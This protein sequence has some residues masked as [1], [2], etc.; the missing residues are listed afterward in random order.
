MLDRTKFLT[1][2]VDL[3]KI[4]EQTRLFILNNQKRRVLQGDHHARAG[5]ILI[6][7][8]MMSETGREEVLKRQKELRERKLSRIRAFVPKTRSTRGLR[9]LIAIAGLL[10]VAIANREFG[11]S[12]E[13]AVAT[14]GFLTYVIEALVEYRAGRPLILSLLRAAFPVMTLVV[15][16]LVLFAGVSIFK[17]NS[18]V[19]VHSAGQVQAQV[20]SRLNGIRI[21]FVAM[22]GALAILL[23][24][25][26]WKFH[27]LRFAES[28][29]GAMKDI[30]IRVESILRDETRLIDE[31]KATAMMVALKGLR[32]VI[33]LSV[34]DRVI[35][36]IF[37]FRPSANQARVLFFVPNSIGDAFELQA[38]AYPE[39]AP[40]GV[41]DAFDCIRDNH[42]P[43]ILNEEKFEQLKQ[44]AKGTS[45]R[46]WKQRYLVF[47]ER[48]EHISIC[49]WIYDKQETLIAMDA[50][51]CLAFDNSFLKRIRDAGGFGKEVLPWLEPGSFIG[52]PIIGL[53]GR[54]AGVLLVI[55]NIRN[56]F[57][58]EDLEAVIMASQIMG[59]IL[60]TGNP[61]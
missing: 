48:H 57:A 55:K 36:W 23:M 35:R 20:Q 45:P 59:N 38:A 14:A 43:R 39:D 49:G 12:L 21:A 6:Q 17:L 54:P 7:H 22:A 44:L 30:L 13:L 60:Q 29:L 15:F 33:R 19:T 58:P 1:V 4:S 11:V 34:V 24:Y 40:E 32:N 61:T 46:G 51:D 26:I 42:H 47:T 9:A 16:C 5:E 25:S 31:R 28:R 8:R 52:C 56:G 18:I 2:A 50:S 27:A 53:G 41:R 37:I 3:G 10:G